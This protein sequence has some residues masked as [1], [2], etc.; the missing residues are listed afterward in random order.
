MRKP[1]QEEFTY[2][3]IDLY[4]FNK[5]DLNSVSQI[6]PMGLKAFGSELTDYII[7]N[8]IKEANGDFYCGICSKGPFSKKGIKLHLLRVH[9]KDILE[10]IDEFVMSRIS[11]IKKSRI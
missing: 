2:S 8:I 6:L 5:G 7:K 1:W 3:V 9:Q 10:I 4:L 11:A